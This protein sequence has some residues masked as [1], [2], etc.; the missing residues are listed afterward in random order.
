[1][2]LT[3]LNR[4]RQFVQKDMIKT[5]VRWASHLKDVLPSAAVIHTEAVQWGDIDAFQHVN[6]CVY[7]RY[8]EN[9]RIEYLK[10]VHN[11]APEMDFFSPNGVG[12]IMADAYVRFRAPLYFPDTIYVGIEI[13]NLRETDARMLFKVYSQQQQMVVAEGHGRMVCFDYDKGAKAP[14]PGPVVDAMKTLAD[15]KN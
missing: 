13:D 9:A 4:G 7:L 1:M 2:A 6:N 11:L 10:Q 12:P 15:L 14:L 5:I 8:F 3:T